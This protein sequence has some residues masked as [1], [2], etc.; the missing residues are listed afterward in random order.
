M[1]RC[2]NPSC[3]AHDGE[4][5]LLGLRR[6]DD[7]PS[8]T[9]GSTEPQPDETV[10]DARDDSRVP[11][12]GAALGPADLS[13]LTPRGR[14]I[15]IGVLGSHDAGKSTLLTG[16]YLMM[17][18][19]HRI[20]SAS[21]AGSRSF[22]AWEALAA[23]ARFDD[24]A[25]TP[26]FPPHTSRGTGRVQGLLHLALRGE[27][28]SFRDVL[29]TDAPGEWFTRWAIREDDPEAEGA[30]WIADHADGFLLAADCARLSGEE[31]GEAR[32]ETRALIERLGNH[33]GGRPTI[34]V[35][36]KSDHE[37]PVGV[38]RSIRDALSAQLPHAKQ[39][40]ATTEQPETLIGAVGAVVQAC[41]SPSPGPIVVPPVMSHE[42]FEAFRGHHGSD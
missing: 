18:S 35:W 24:A 7:C 11:W 10:P 34:L 17:L 22:E 38:R 13:I 37:P 39:V 12:S 5:C 21:F 15:L 16:T 36:T 32:R 33:V 1:K 31:R 4:S 41:W 3:F 20:G 28:N 14:P 42:P 29:L 23:W 27:D 9:M 25:R 30:Q 19:G 8:W 2:N 6:V 40:E 26:T